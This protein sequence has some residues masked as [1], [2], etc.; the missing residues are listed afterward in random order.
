VRGRDGSA[1]WSTRH[2]R[3]PTKCRGSPNN[4]QP[5]PG[6]CNS[7]HRV[8]QDC[9]QETLPRQGHEA[10]PAR[11]QS[12]KG[13][14][15]NV[16]GRGCHQ[17]QRGPATAL[18]SQL[19][20]AALVAAAPQVVLHELIWHLQA[21]VAF[22]CRTASLCSVAVLA[23]RHSHSHSR[24]VELPHSRLGC[25]VP[26]GAARPACAAAAPC[27]RPSRCCCSRA[28]VRVRGCWG[29]GVV[30]AWLAR[31][32][33]THTLRTPFWFLRAAEQSDQLPR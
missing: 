7:L 12:S 18:H 13:T 10:N 30:L 25:T 2:T 17:R 24:S 33:V 23:C 27:R 11:Q 29:G 1:G 8:C 21:G 19:G 16:L 5:N 28:A 26:G 3:C 4:N 15:G 14:V 22:A 9:S 31:V 20:V 6:S 32:E